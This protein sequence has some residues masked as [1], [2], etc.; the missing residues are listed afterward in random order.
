MNDS[1]KIKLLAGTTILLIVMNIII[2]GFIWFGRTA[3]LPGRARPG[4]ERSEIIIRELKLND[5]QRTQFEKL[6]DEHRHIMMTVNEKDRHTHEALFDLIK[7]GQDSTAASDSLIHEI[8]ANRMLIEHATAHHLAQVRR[9][10]TPEQQKIFDDIII[11]LFKRG[12]EG[13]PPGR[14]P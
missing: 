4:A 12:P 2:V 8:A 13:P 11:T 1:S 5:T 9:I 6:R 3:P 10:C 7:T 14:R